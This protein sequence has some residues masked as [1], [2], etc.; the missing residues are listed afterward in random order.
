MKILILILFTLIMSIG[1]LLFKKA[2]LEINWNEGVL[3]FLNPWLIVAVILY[4][5]AT[6]I[7]VWILRTVPLNFAYPFTAIA[8]VIV[9]VA[10]SIL[11]KENLGWQNVVGTILVMAG[12]AVISLKEI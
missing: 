6:L 4:G 8:F 1:Q 3:G 2:S 9:P 12:I 5:F 7:W 10:A 11:F